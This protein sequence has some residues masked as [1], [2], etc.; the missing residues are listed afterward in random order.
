MTLRQLALLRSYLELASLKEA[1]CAQGVAFQTAKNHLT[2]L[3]RSL[4]VHSAIEASVALGWTR[5]PD[6]PEL[7]R[8]GAMTGRCLLQPGHTGAHRGAKVA[9]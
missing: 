3:Y 8:C 2:A 6:L 7:P 9:A 5:L 1:A 4:G